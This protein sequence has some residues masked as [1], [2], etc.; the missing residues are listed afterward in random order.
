MFVIYIYGRVSLILFSLPSARQ[1][2]WPIPLG[3]PVAHTLW[4]PVAHT[5]LAASGPYPWTAS[6]PYQR[7]PSRPIPTSTTFFPLRVQAGIVSDSKRSSPGHF[8]SMSFS[9]GAFVLCSDP[10]SFVTFYKG[11]MFYIKKMIILY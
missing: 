10:C 9:S 2:S 8:H 6:G 11:I 7:Q 3:Q 1:T 5:S 4:Q